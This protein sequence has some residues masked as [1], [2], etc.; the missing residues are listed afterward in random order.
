M[1][2]TPPRSSTVCRLYLDS[3]FVMADA[4]FFSWVSSCEA[5]HL[6]GFS[7]VFSD[8]DLFL[9]HKNPEGHHSGR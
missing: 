4:G 9:C 8:I 7:S 2:A 6:G 5:A 1:D 3:V